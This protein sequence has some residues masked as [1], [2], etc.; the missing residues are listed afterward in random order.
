MLELVSFLSCSATILIVQGYE[1]VFQKKLKI[2]VAPRDLV[3]LHKWFQ[4]F[5]FFLE[6]DHLP[7]WSWPFHAFVHNTNAVFFL[8][9]CSRHASHQ[10]HKGYSRPL[11]SY[12]YDN[13]IRLMLV[14]SHKS[15]NTHSQRS[16]FVKLLHY[17][18]ILQGY[19]G[20]VK[21]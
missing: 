19:G 17:G 1:T 21:K 2:L 12:F 18:E 13:I 20:T 5:I 14:G 11:W 9:S 3:F 10:E 4:T 8:F 7:R 16:L 15:R 6:E